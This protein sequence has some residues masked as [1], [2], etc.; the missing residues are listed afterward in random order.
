MNVL[1]K[2]V[3]SIAFL[4]FISATV[5]AQCVNSTAL[6]GPTQLC[7]GAR[8]IYYIDYSTHKG[9]TISLSVTGGK[10]LI[11]QTSTL[12]SKNAR[13]GFMI[14]WDATPDSSN[15]IGTIAIHKSARRCSSTETVSVFIQNE[16]NCN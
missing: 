4:F 13:I 7:E 5:T 15:A 11:N 10:L 1:S 16:S 14:E 12:N 3:C 6:N 8:G 9:G 2:L